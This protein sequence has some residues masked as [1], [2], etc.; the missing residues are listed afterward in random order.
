LRKSS[1]IG[2]GSILSRYFP[3]LEEAVLAY[4]ATLPA[5]KAKGG[6]L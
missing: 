1:G 4:R 5:E 3:T 2:E 6:T